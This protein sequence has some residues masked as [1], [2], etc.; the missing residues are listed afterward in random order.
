VDGYKRLI[1]IAMLQEPWPSAWRSYAVDADADTHEM[2]HGAFDLFDVPIF[3]NAEDAA[4]Q[5]AAYVMLRFGK[6]EAR[7]LVI[8]PAQRFFNLLCLAYGAE[9]FLFVD[10]G[11]LPKDRATNCKREYDQVTFAFRGLI[12]PHLDQQLARK[13]LD[14]QGSTSLLRTA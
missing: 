14:R 10:K 8:A 11:Y 9:P 1:V 3:G 5:F 13:A 4:D 2:G 7:R 12:V 6:E